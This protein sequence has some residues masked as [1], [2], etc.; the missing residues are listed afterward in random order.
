MQ[1][2]SDNQQFSVTTCEVTELV[3]VRSLKSVCV[4]P[5]SEPLFK[6]AL[7]ARWTGVQNVVP[8]KQSCFQSDLKRVLKGVFEKCVHMK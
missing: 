2:K 8:F 1:A 5:S 7:P 3:E 4:N 6:V